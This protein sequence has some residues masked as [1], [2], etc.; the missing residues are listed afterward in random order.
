[1]SI[2]TSLFSSFSNLSNDSFVLESN[3]PS[4]S[5][6]INEFPED[7]NLFSIIHSIHSSFK[8]YTSTSSILSLSK[9]LSSLRSL[10]KHQRK[11][12]LQ[13]FNDLIDHFTSLLYISDSILYNEAILKSSLYL[14]HELFTSYQ[15]EDIYNEWLPLI[16]HKLLSL[17]VTRCDEELSSLTNQCITDAISNCYEVEDFAETLIEFAFDEDIKVAYKSSEI[18][19]EL[20]RKGREQRKKINFLNVIEKVN[21]LLDSEYEDYTKIG[22]K[23]LNDIKENVSESELAIYDIDKSSFFS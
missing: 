3:L 7:S 16:L 13:V 12:F 17:S 15:N 22:M 19:N 2:K 14:L 6:S 11:I 23:I 21:S 4:L 9:S 1:M 18:F 20:L 10:L 8:E 5:H